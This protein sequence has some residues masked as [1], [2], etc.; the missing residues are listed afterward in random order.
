MGVH[1]GLVKFVVLRIYEPTY[2]ERAAADDARE[3]LVSNSFSELKLNLKFVK[4]QHQIEMNSKSDWKRLRLILSL[5]SCPSSSLVHCKQP[6]QLSI[7]PRCLYTSALSATDSLGIAH[8]RC[9]GC[10]L[11]QG[12][13]STSREA[14]SKKPNLL[15]TL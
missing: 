13:S 11:D 2:Y 10:R 15:S 4:T 6:C 3:V 1:Y 12:L 14:G 8:C 5:V 9:S 7:H